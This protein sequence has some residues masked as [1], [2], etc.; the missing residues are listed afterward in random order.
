MLFSKRKLTIEL[1][2]HI[3][4]RALHMYVIKPITSLKQILPNLIRAWHREERKLGRLYPNDLWQSWRIIQRPLSLECGC[5]F[6]WLF[7][8]SM[9]FV[10]SSKWRNKEPP[11][12][13]KQRKGH[14]NCWNLKVTGCSNC[15]QA[16]PINIMG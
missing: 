7:W 13:G 12:L 4:L 8:F 16:C 5:S 3:W 14:Q 10:W 1:V 6:F 2:K 15:P 11:N 9:E